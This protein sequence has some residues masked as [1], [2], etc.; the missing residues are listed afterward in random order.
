MKKYQNHLRMYRVHTGQE[1][2][3][4]WLDWIKCKIQAIY[5]FSPS[6]IAYAISEEAVEGIKNHRRI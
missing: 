6:K 5:G 2:P 4:N 3:K 1:K